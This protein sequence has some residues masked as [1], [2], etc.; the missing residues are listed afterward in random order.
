MR[1][2]QLRE[3]GDTFSGNESLMKTKNIDSSSSRI[4]ELSKKGKTAMFVADD[5]AGQ[6]FLAA[7]DDSSSA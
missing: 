7:A 2:R 3:G 4:V 1:F 6:Y 5:K